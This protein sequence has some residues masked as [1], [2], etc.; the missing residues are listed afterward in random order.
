MRPTPTP[1]QAASQ[2]RRL[3]R[4][5]RR[6]SG[7]LPALVIAFG[8]VSAGLIAVIGVKT[9]GFGIG[10]HNAWLNYAANLAS[11]DEPVYFESLIPAEIPPDANFFKDSLFDP[12]TNSTP[13]ADTRDLLQMVIDPGQG[14]SVDTL[15]DASAEGTNRATLESIAS[16]MATA[17]VTNPGTDYL[18]PG[19]RILAGFSQMGLDFSPLQ[20]ASDRAEARF[21]IDY[22]QVDPPTLPHLQVLEAMADWLAIRAVAFISTGNSQSAAEDLLLV[23]RLADSVANEPFLESQRC[24]RKLLEIFCSGILTGIKRDAWSLEE[25]EDFCVILSRSRPL[26]DL[27]LAIRGERGRLNTAIDARLLRDDLEPSALIQSW[28]DAPGAALPL[29]QMRASQILIN[30]AIQELV[31][32]V[33]SPLPPT[34]DTQDSSTENESAIPSPVVDLPI[35]ARQRL[36]TLE[37]EADSFRKTNAL[38]I[39]TAAACAQQ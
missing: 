2:W 29:R 14:I 22:S 10:I 37:E 21:P 28:F 12:L 18:L 35:S 15:L 27:A 8:V 7:F 6:R 9:D 20:S 17:G 11:Q 26:S 39:E 13:R 1:P 31:N 32:Q 23:A 33:L 30:T 4:S 5:R 38:V 36:A 16:Q 34:D 3:G 19:D 24:R 25:R